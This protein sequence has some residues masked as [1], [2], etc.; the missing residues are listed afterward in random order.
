MERPVRQAVLLAG[1]ALTMSTQEYAAREYA[2]RR[3]ASGAQ[4]ENALEGAREVRDNLAE[5]I[6]RSVER[7][8]HT[9]LAM[10]VALGFLLG[11]V[12]AR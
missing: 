4:R 11:A 8:P 7:H 1:R 9:T 2:A 3:S 10:A 12:W 6:E 5:A